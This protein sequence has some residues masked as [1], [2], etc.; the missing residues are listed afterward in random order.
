MTN[1]HLRYNN[2]GSQGLNYLSNL[3]HFDSIQ[4]LDLMNNNIASE[5]IRCLTSSDRFKRLNSLFLFGNKIGAKGAGYLAATSSFPELISLDIG[6]NGLGVDGIKAFFNNQIS[7]NL[8]KLKNLFINN[9][10][11]QDTGVR[12][13]LLDHNSILVM[14]H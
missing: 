7:F 3:S 13:I 4:G 11:V 1:L 8:K 6:E 14:N 2:I 10:E 9:N 12:V 5:G